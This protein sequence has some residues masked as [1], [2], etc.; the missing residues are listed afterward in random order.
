MLGYN[1]KLV[2]LKLN[3]VKK[4][5]IEELVKLTGLEQVAIMRALLTLEKEGLAK[6]SERKERIIRLTDLGRKYIQMGLPEIRALNVLKSK[7]KVKL[8]ELRG[9]LTEDELKPIVGILRKEGWVK[10]EKTPEGLVLEITE[11]GENPEERPIDKALKI[12]SE[13]EYATSEEISKIVPINE[14]KRRKVAQEEEVVERIAE[15]TEKGVELVKKGIEL[16]REVT[17][18]TPELIASGKWR[19]VEF[20]PFNIKAPVKKI[21]PGKKQ[22]YRVFLDKIRRKLIEMGFIEIT[23][24]SLIETQFW[25]FDA[26]FQPQNHPARE[27]TD[28]YQL[29][30]PEK[31]YLPNRELVERV[32]EAHERGLAGS[33]GWGYVWSPERAMFLMPRAHATALSA[34]QLAK[35]I[36]IPGKYFTIQRVFRPDVLD[37]THLIEFNQIDGFVAA[38][39]LTFRHLLGILKKFAIEIAGAKKVKFFP[40]Y[41]PFTEPSVQLSA[42]HPEL[43]WVEFGGAGVFREEMTKALGIDVPVIAWG[44]G[45]DRLA[46]FRLGIDDIRYLFSYDLKWLREAKLIW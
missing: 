44:I 28:T 33:R 18:L 13:K 37:R 39:D 19:E 25:N 42:Y 26:L 21:Y 6:I 38:E 14:L 23:V 27:W 34:R 36:E 40:D 35:G 46:M 4:A 17:S 45:I 20:K 2:L 9:V 7:K 3:E 30:Y 12:L 43:G 31:G 5:R 29:K 22:P 16:K 24:D 15:I 8:D 32:K 11:R 10:V 41:Y 1:E